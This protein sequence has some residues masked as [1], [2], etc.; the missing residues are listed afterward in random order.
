VGVYDRFRYGVALLLVGFAPAS[1][2]FWLV[3]HPLARFWR[4]VGYRWGYVAG[5]ALS[6]A[7]VA[8]SLRFRGAIARTDLGASAVTGVLGAVLLGIAVAMRRHWQRQLSAG[9]MFGLPELAPRQYPGRL[10]TEG[11]YARV[12]HP[13]YLQVVVAIAGW[14]LLANYLAGYLVVL[15]VVAELAAIIPLEERELADRFGAE[16]EAYRRRVPALLPRWGP[17]R[18]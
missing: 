13:R 14:A 10:L 15:V 17:P 9:T 11:I 7:T 16:Y 6:V 5:F 3:V 4:R 2:L 12:R 1:V 8:A 18:E